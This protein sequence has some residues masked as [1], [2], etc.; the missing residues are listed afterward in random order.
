MDISI[1]ANGSTNIYPKR[2]M[3]CYHPKYGYGIIYDYAS[4]NRNDDWIHVLLET[5]MVNRFGQEILVMGC[6]CSCIPYGDDEKFTTCSNEDYVAGN[7]DR[8]RK[9]D[10]LMRCINCTLLTDCSYGASLSR[11]RTPYVV[12]DKHVYNNDIHCY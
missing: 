1:H 4:E 10:N 2:G 3:K 11:T 12:C 8:I 5:P 6:N 9:A 7:T